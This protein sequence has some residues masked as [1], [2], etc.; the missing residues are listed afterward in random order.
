VSLVQSG[1]VK[2]CR[3]ID[4]GCGTATNVIFLTQN[5]FDVTG[6]DFIPAAIE[7]GRFKLQQAGARANLVVDDLTNLQHIN[8]TFD[9]LVD[10]GTLDDL[11]TSRR[12]LYMKNVLPL[13]HINGTFDLLVDYGTLDDLS[14]SRR[15]LYMKNVLPLTHPG[16]LFLLF[17]GEWTPRWWERMFLDGAALK[18]GEVECRFGEHFNVEVLSR[19]ETGSVFMPMWA[20]YLLT[21]K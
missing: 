14:T 8:G 5:G 3:A 17:C 9:L 12:D 6:V 18:P 7:I 21:R 11:S 4:L 19:E 13:T 15:D 2:P 1:R 16:S 20:T 10:Y